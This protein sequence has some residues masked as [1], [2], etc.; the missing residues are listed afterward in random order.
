MVKHLKLS[1]F[2]L[3]SRLFCCLLL[4]SVLSAVVIGT[5]SCLISLENAKQRYTDNLTYYLKTADTAIY[6]K[7]HDLDERMI[8]TALDASVI[9]SLEK[10]TAS[11]NDAYYTL[12]KAVYSNKMI[13]SADVVVVLDSDGKSYPL[14]STQVSNNEVEGALIALNNKLGDNILRLWGEPLRTQS[15]IFIPYVRK[16]IK[17]GNGI[18]KKTTQGVLAVYLNETRLAKEL[19]K[20]F[21]LDEANETEGLLIIGKNGVIYSARDK[22]I[23]GSSVYEVFGEETL[24][25]GTLV[26]LQGERKLLVLYSYPNREYQL[27][28]IVDYR[29][30]SS[31]ARRIL[32]ITG[33]MMTFA[34][35]VCALL[36]L[37]L[38]KQIV[39]PIN[40]LITAVNA[41][42]DEHLQCA[43]IPKYNDEIS[44]L[45]HSFINM[46]KRLE[47]SRDINKKLQERFIQAEYRALM[48]QINPHFLYNTLSSVI[49]L[50]ED[51]RKEESISIV[52]ALAKLFRTGIRN[53]NVLTSVNEEV[54]YTK[55]YLEIQKFR[56][57]N[58]I[59]VIDVPLDILQ[60]LTVKLTLQ[61]LVENALYHGIRDIENGI[62]L[63]C[64]HF[65]G[66]MLIFEVKDNGVNV[67]QQELDNINAYLVTDS[68][69]NPRCGIGVKNV[70]DRIRFQYGEGCGVRLSREGGYTIARMCIPCWAL[71]ERTKNV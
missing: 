62:I 5:F 10:K 2:N 31:T 13:L 57:H 40:K 43:F 15:G 58:F 48:A 35:L 28:A 26:R 71:A 65:E 14:Y 4:V 56:Y 22:S 64:A 67:T 60:M 44:N 6:A 42:D 29:I 41:V 59:Y 33:G 7:Q 8:R 39:K 68:P 16:I 61:P 18:A 9:S 49:Y 51:G 19:E 21:S 23:I 25:S 66:E 38:S 52:S 3:R 1:G 70:N 11:Y 12:Q 54:E 55:S 27:A 32:Y 30:V 63:I 36:S 53:D 20:T 46:T 45:G 24:T 34:I 69:E 47:Q 37:S 17:Y 50:V